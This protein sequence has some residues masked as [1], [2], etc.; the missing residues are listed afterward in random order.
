MSVVFVVNAEQTFHKGGFSG[1][2]FSHEGVDGT[3]LKLQTYMVQSLDTGKGLGYIFHFQQN[4]LLHTAFLPCEFFRGETGDRERH[5]PRDSSGS[6]ICRSL[7]KRRVCCVCS[8]Q[9]ARRENCLSR[10]FLRKGQLPPERQLPGMIQGA[11][12]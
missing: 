3:F 10:R 11:F 12:C 6:G 8:G 5:M 1:A 4:I 2:V 7:P 9:N